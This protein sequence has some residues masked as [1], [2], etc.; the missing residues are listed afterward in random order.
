MTRQLSTHCQCVAHVINNSLSGAC[1]DIK[2][3][4]PSIWIPVIKITRSW[5]R[6]ISIISIVKSIPDY[7]NSCISDDQ[8]RVPLQWRH[9]GR[10]DVSNHQRLDCLLNRLFRRRSK[11][12][13]KPHVTGLCDGNPPVTGEFP[14]R[15]ASHM[16]N[17]SIWWRHHAYIRTPSTHLKWSSNGIEY[18]STADAYIETSWHH[19]GLSI[20]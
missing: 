2:A 12:T 20:L 8:L 5:N 9:N 7:I 19:T 3:V 15:G 1:C 4:F 18:S 11:K 16:E 14:A 10:D 17:V 6:F 13:S